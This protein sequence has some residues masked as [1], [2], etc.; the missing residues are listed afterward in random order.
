MQNPFKRYKRIRVS[1]MPFA[2]AVIPRD[3][4]REIRISAASVNP[5]LTRAVSAMIL[6]TFGG[7]FRADGFGGFPTDCRIFRRASLGFPHR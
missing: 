7:Y 2:S 4:A 3:T 6:E 1:A 5:E